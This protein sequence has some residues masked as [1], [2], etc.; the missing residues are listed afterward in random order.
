[1]CGRIVDI[2]L[3]QKIAGFAEREWSQLYRLGEAV[4][5]TALGLNDVFDHPRCGATT[6]DQLDLLDLT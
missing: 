4:V 6:D 3:A 1:M 2:A 5:Q